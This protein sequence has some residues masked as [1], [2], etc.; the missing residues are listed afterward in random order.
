MYTLVTGRAPKAWSDQTKPVSRTRPALPLTMEDKMSQ[1][2]ILSKDLVAL[3]LYIE[4]DDHNVYL[5]Y[6]GETIGRWWATAARL[7]SIRN[8]ARTWAKKHDKKIPA[9]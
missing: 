9:G 2:A 8:A 5:K 1:N 3:G 6:M 7:A 4:E